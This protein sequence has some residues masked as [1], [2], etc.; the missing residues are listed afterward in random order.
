MAVVNALAYYNTATILAIK[1]LKYRLLE[2][3]YS[4]ISALQIDN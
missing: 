4:S 2:N 3:R 1:I